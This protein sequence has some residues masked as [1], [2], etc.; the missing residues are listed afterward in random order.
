MI[1][2]GSSNAGIGLP[3]GMDILKAGGSALDAVEA[4][5]RMVE[6][7]P[8]DHSV[9]LGGLPNLVGEVELDASLMDGD[10]LAAGAVGAVR[11]FLH[12]I[13]IARRVMEDLPH[14]LLVGPG[15]E[16]FARECGFESQ[17]LL[18]AAARH[19]YEEGLRGHHDAGTGDMDP[20]L[21][22]LSGRLARDPNRASGRDTGTVNVLALDGAGHLASGVSTSGF[23][24]K[25]PGRVGDSAI[26]GAGNYADDRYGAA[27]CTGRGEMA[28]RAATAHTAVTHL[29]AGFSPEEA[30][31]RAMEEL[32][33]L[34]DPYWGAMN[35]VILAPDGQHAG[36]STVPETRYVYMTP[37]STGAAE[38]P[39]RWI[40]VSGSRT[41]T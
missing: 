11:G 6:E 16:R 10:T 39:R 29:R 22:A 9:G 37:D 24:W 20:V 36:F 4:A 25:Y 35:L 26:I 23:A 5:I 14:S 32:D 8:D 41:R 7:N 18:T 31:R 30:G 40:A 13:S 38:A 33:R 12:P 27:A 15:A 1:I 21:R 19:I 17:E 3:A 28:M 34:V 2:V